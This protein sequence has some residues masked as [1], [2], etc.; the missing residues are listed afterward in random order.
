MKLLINRLMPFF[1]LIYILLIV[2]LRLRSRFIGPIATNFDIIKVITYII[3]LLIVLSGL[4]HFLRFYYYSKKGTAKSELAVLVKDTWVTRLLQKTSKFISDTLDSFMYRWVIGWF[5]GKKYYHA[6]LTKIGLFIAN[7]YDKYMKHVLIGLLIIPPFIVPL[8]YF[9]D[10]VY[11]REF[12]YFPNLAF[13]IIFTLITK[14]ILYF[15]KTGAEAGMQSLEEKYVFTLEKNYRISQITVRDVRDNDTYGT[16]TML[17]HFL[18]E[19]R[20]YL[21]IYLIFKAT[22]E[23]LDN[24]YPVFRKMFALLCFVSAWTILLYLQLLFLL[25]IL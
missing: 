1:G 15:L 9:V 5:L 11:Y 22:E 6:V 2:Y 25:F 19:F 13:L 21:D 16:E 17:L 8:A 3:L 12:Y 20:D 4:I 7:R 18:N 23:K 10:V 24:L 14:A